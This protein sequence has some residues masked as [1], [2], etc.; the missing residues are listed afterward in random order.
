MW[1]IDITKSP[2]AKAKPVSDSIDIH[3]LTPD[4]YLYLNTS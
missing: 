4:Y 3:S 2:K 1:D